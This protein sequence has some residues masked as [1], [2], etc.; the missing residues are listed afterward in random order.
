VRVGVLAAARRERR[1][2]RTARRGALAVQRAAQAPQLGLDLT[3]LPG[4]P[5]RCQVRLVRAA[6][7]LVRSRVV[8][9]QML[10]I[11]PPGAGFRMCHVVL[12]SFGE[13]YE[14]S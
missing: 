10:D 7:C 5:A 9:S 11:S 14:V 12:S 3:A 13:A 2:G 8:V 4:G 1:L 6:A